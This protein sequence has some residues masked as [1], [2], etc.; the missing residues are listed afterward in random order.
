V[1][2]FLRKS[3]TKFLLA[4]LKTLACCDIYILK[5]ACYC[6]T[7]SETP[8]KIQT[9][10]ACRE[11]TDLIFNSC[12]KKSS[13]GEPIPLILVQQLLSTNLREIMFLLSLTSSRT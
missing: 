13:S 4:S 10:G 11:S 5:A 8:W 12:K 3:D 6:K 2:L 7:C 9:I 1:L